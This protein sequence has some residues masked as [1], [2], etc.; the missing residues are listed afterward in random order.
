VSIEA[1]RWALSVAPDV[2]PNLLAPLITL[3]DHANEYGMSYPS[4]ELL[5]FEVRKSDRA[6]RNDL[7]AL[8]ARCLIRRGDQRFVAHLPVDRRPVVWEMAMELV[9]RER[10]QWLADRR[11]YGRNPASGRSGTGGTTVPPNPQENPQRE[12]PPPALTH[13]REPAAVE[14]EEIEGIDIGSVLDEVQ[15]LRPGWSV[16]AVCKVLR[17]AVAEGRSPEEAKRVLIEHAQGRWDEL[18]GRKTI[19]PRRILADGP[20]WAQRAAEPVQRRRISRP[21]APPVRTS[22]STEAKA[23][24]DATLAKARSNSR[25]VKT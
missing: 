18:G 9:D 5:A 4:Q 24:I 17:D 16:R 15:K 6:V 25:K 13:R 1:I 20:W 3:A 12:T 14:E 10:E 21:P 22:R 23:A 8:E 2:P 19:S 7:A 11:Q